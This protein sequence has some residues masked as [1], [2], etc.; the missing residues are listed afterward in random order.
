MRILVVE[1]DPRRRRNAG[2]K[3][4]AAG[5]SPVFAGSYDA[6]QDALRKGGVDAVLASLFHPESEENPI[7]PLA[8]EQIDWLDRGRERGS[9]WNPPLPNTFGG[10]GSPFAPLGLRL[11]GHCREEYP[12]VPAVSYTS[13]TGS[14]LAR[15]FTWRRAGMS[16]RGTLSFPWI[17]LGG[18]WGYDWG[19]A[20]AGLAEAETGLRPSLSKSWDVLMAEPA[21]ARLALFGV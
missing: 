15:Q 7:G 9:P 20:A 14:N 21:E 10:T 1:S 2:R 8:R 17:L 4:S 18:A 6:A 11:A 19:A 3:L 13:G 12:E 16:F 5:P